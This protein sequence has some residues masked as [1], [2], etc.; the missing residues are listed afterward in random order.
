MSSGRIT[1]ATAALAIL[2]AGGSTLIG[3][4]KTPDPPP[5]VRVVFGGDV[6]IGR[7]VGDEIGR[8]HV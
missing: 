5:V 8:A 3:A 2:L 7:A 4:E 1:K 6:M